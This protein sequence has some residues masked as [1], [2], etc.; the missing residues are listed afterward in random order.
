MKR[1]NVLAL[2]SSATLLMLPEWAAGQPAGQHIAPVVGFLGSAP[3]DG[4]QDV[5]ATFRAG[6]SEGGFVD[7]HNVTIEFRWADN[8][9]D[10]LAELATDLVRRNVALIVASGGAVSALAAKSATSSIPVIFTAVADPVRGG[11]VASM[12]RPGGNLTGTAAL[13][14]E[15]DPKRLELLAKLAPGA[16]V[17]GAIFNPKRPNADVQ[18]AQVRAA[19]HKL[20]RELAIADV[21][22]EP[23]FPGIFA[24]LAKNGVGAILLG[25]DPL[26]RTRL[27]EIASL[28]SHLA[29][30]TIWQFREFAANGGLASYGPSLLDSYREAGIYAAR[31]L[32]GE[33]VGD[34]PVIQPTKFDFV[35]NLKTAKTLGLDI[36]PTLL[37]IANE[38]IE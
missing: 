13:T 30:P 28:A 10:R 34:L 15:L 38:V 27:A 1:R 31:I 23:D 6:L 20:G 18:Q 2:L 35:I 29:L 9:Y 11:L 37:A 17:I 12:N 19:A 26:F 36:P 7:G 5:V 22:P 14:D 21:G 24:G 33:K 32:K 16:K 25:A 8:H 4:F 3:A